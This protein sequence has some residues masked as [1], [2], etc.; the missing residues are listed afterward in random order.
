MIR[1]TGVC[2]LGC[3]AAL[4]LVSGAL[5]AV[6]W[7]VPPIVLP[8]GER[9]P[10]IACTPVELDRLR[11]AYRASGPEHDVVAAVVARADRAA[12]RPIEFPPRG[13]QHNQWYQCDKCQ[14]AL[15]T[16]D[17]THHRCPRCKTVYT[18]E[19]YDDVIFA[20]KHGEN[21][22][23]MEA[24]AWAYAITGEVRYA[25]HA[26]AVLLGYAQRYKEYPYHDSSRRTG[27]AA[28]RS[29]GHLAEQT[30]NE[31]ASLAGEIAP[32]YDLI[33]DAP[34]LSAAD[35]EKIRSGLLLP[36]LQNI[37]KNK[38]GKSN[39]QTW[40]NAAMLWTAPLV[41]DVAW[42]RKA[43]TQP[44]NG[45]LYQMDVSVSDDGM[46]Y[47]NSWGYH[48]YTLRAMVHIVE[49]ARRLGID[50]WSHPS[51]RKM[52]TVP[53]EYAMPDGSLPRFGDDVR[54]TIGHA[55]SYLEFAYHAYRDPAML[56]HLPAR[57]SWDSVMLGRK[58]GARPRT[59]QP[60]SKVFPSAGHTVLRARGEA[61][62]AAVI[63]F[64]PYGG[65]HGHFDKL[66]FVFFGYGEELGV[67]PGRAR[68]Q[69]YRLP[70]HR[71]WY[72]ATIGHNAVLVDAA[73]QKPASGKL[74]FFQADDRSA[75]AVA[76]CDEAYPG[77]AHRRAMWLLPDALVVFDELKSST[78][79]RFDWFYHHRG[80]GA[81]CDA[82]TKDDRL[83]E[84]YPGQEYV[85]HVLAG[86]TE[87]AVRIEFAG[88]GV[89]TYLTMDAAPGTE[90]R[91]GDGVGGSID[92]R[93][94][95]AAITR[96]GREA[97]F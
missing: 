4:V 46:W 6:P 58:V 80:T 49:G 51:L 2:A 14:I 88:R 77:V 71:D 59:V 74:E 79:R 41:G 32:A 34:I 63:T 39:W 13:G 26:K 83:G 65:F 33:H 10:V 62:L 11:A 94:P 8:A 12:K 52:F 92:D 31:S 96:R 21:L 5:G 20:R 70:I 89:T 68:S 75:V 30:L 18:G 9:H 24:A 67:D 56:V 15:R 17:D 54:T 66:S 72:K 61:G 85:E 93:V 45:F 1:R 73:S 55:S 87:K 42:A 44:Q 91:I 81:R 95:M 69:A 47:E 38:A 23:G 50:L 25:E 35:H 78:P 84:K 40:H 16:V 48:F 27:K 86:T 76:R 64:G 82:A 37:D 53:V 90:V 36:M 29:G 22:Q 19:P 57:A 97:R 3:L 43:I 28:G 7:Q 60:S